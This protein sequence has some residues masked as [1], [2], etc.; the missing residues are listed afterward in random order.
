[1]HT[2]ESVDR[3]GIERG[4]FGKLK[5]VFNYGSVQVWKMFV[6]EKEAVSGVLLRC[7]YRGNVDLGLFINGK[8]PGGNIIY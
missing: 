1:M 5:V 4:H 7:R 8:R 3:S 6:A 2:V